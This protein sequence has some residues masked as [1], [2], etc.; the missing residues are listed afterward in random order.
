MRS[1]LGPPPL[2]GVCCRPAGPLPY[3]GP[4]LDADLRR[5]AQSGAGPAQSG[6]SGADD[7]RDTEDWGGGVI[8]PPPAEWQTWRTRGGRG[9][10]GSVLTSQCRVERRW[11]TG[12]EN[13][14]RGRAETWTRVFFSFFLVDYSCH[15]PE[16]LEKI[17]IWTSFNLEY[18]YLRSQEHLKRRFLIV[19]SSSPNAVG[20]VLLKT[21][22]CGDRM[23]H[24][25]SCRC[26]A[27][28][29]ATEHACGCPCIYV[30]AS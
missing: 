13:R 2:R 19:Y 24:A 23:S 20:V 16:F 5:S 27:P 14:H 1:E 10:G 22:A 26:H 7:T 17:L 11:I 8:R 12:T 18:M 29:W 28:R 30:D 4:A 15:K 25:N 9:G 6:A 3:S 21:E